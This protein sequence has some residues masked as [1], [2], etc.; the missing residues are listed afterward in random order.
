MKMKSPHWIVAGMLA[1]GVTVSVQSA[2]A[3]NDELVK[4][5]PFTVNSS[6]DRGYTAANAVSAT[7]VSTGI[8]DLPFS[9][10]SFTPQFIADTGSATLLEI[11]S[12]SA[13]VK[14]AVF[15]NTQGDA[16]YSVR[17]FPQAPQRDG[18]G[19]AR[20]ANNYVAAAAIDRV[21]IVKGPASLLYGAIAPGGTVNYITKAP[22]EKPFTE[23]R[24]AI[25]SYNYG[26]ATLD[27]NRPLIPQKL[28]FRLVTSYENS[29]QYIQNV[30]GHTVLL[31]P[32]VKWLLTP[33][34]SV[35]LSYQLYQNREAPPAMYLANTNLA[36][37]ASV[38]AA[39]YNPGYPAPT[40]FLV[41]RTGPAVAQG[42]QDVSDP[43]FMGPTPVMPRN[44]N[45]SDVKDIRM[46]DLKVYSAE[47]N[48][49][50][51]DH[52]TGRGHVGVDVDK[53]TFLETGHV[54]LFLPPPDSLV[55]T[56]NVWSVAPSWTAAPLAQQVAQTLAY[57]ERAVNDLSLLRST[58]N[59]TP[60]PALIDRA[61]RV[62]EQWMNATTI[63][64]EA[65]GIYSYPGARLSILGGAFYSKVRFNVR[66]TQNRGNAA[67]PF[68]RT[69]DVNPASPTY[70]VN[71][72]VAKY[73][74]N[75]L[76]VVNT[77]STTRTSEKA[78][79]AL[80]SGSM[81][82]NHLFVVGGVRHSRGN[83]QV[84]DQLTK[85]Y[86]RALDSKA[87]MPQLGLG[88]KV[89][90]NLMVY[91]SISQSYTVSEQPFLTV[92]GVVNGVPSAIPTTATAPTVGTGVEAGIKLGLL[93]N[94][95]TATISFFQ[96]D[97]DDVLQRLNTNVQGSGLTIWNQGAKQRGRGVEGTLL[98]SPSKVWHIVAS[99]SEQD[100]R[101]V[102]E[103][104]GLDYYLG[105]VTGYSAKTS[106]N[107]WTRY[108]L[109]SDA[110]KGW[111]I[112]GGVSY[113]GKNAGDPRN[114]NY[115]LPA[116]TLVNSAVG[117]DWK[118]N[119]VKMNTV[120][121]FKNMGNEF[122]KASANYI[123]EPRRLLLSTTM[124]F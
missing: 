43:G 39:F 10:T 99:V 12:Q 96:I 93:E 46:N 82:D 34:L 32:E 80:V 55:F 113:T 30:G 77:Y 8:L 21:E 120:L 59:G 60:S 29:E 47:V 45:I 42:V 67:S 63:Q 118:W 88:Y 70:Y 79:Y 94:N 87:T 103:P 102:K 105:Q 20:L 48:A 100:V 56:N 62:Q 98:W 13:G 107:V 78:A 89:T 124:R 75:S 64:A 18:F 44:F 6:N 91:G 4:L 7:R 2:A 108:D 53:M 71:P 23:T 65:V 122:Y 84:Y 50:F 16:I 27:L 95:L 106:A 117:L 97:V 14:A 51:D 35:S 3:A 116:Y 110:L 37:P 36:T 28:L 101:N 66:T 73:D 92:A 11:V 68:F 38:V 76:N 115:F 52:W 58:Q 49:K 19:S 61:P 86:S 85:I 5:D 26:V 15:S 17:G 112:G 90:Q 123:G 74:G 114:K 31:Y 69:W 57:A 22:E 72:D 119:N 83:S 81:L 121:N 111:W 54:T 104:V 33:K 25:G 41:N 109:T 40:S 9:I 1:T 24:L